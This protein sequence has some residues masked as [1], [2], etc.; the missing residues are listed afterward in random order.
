MK[1]GLT[2]EEEKMIEIE[3][4]YDDSEEEKKENRK[5]NEMME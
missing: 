5:N 3:G 2:E 4:K 1:R